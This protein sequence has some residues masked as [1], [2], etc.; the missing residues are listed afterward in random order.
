MNLRGKRQQN[1]YA[2]SD[3]AERLYPLR[4]ES[5]P[6]PEPTA[7]PPG[8]QRV[9]VLAARV[10]LGQQL[11]NLLDS[12]EAR[13]GVLGNGGVGD[14]AR[15]CSRVPL[16]MIAE[17]GGEDVLATIREQEA[18]ARRVVERAEFQDAVFRLNRLL[19]KFFRQAAGVGMR[20]DRVRGR[21][22]KWLNSEA[23]RLLAGE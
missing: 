20:T 1:G 10:L 19:D 5:L 13:V 3:R 18:S 12:R 6:L 21:L 23:A 4:Q 15:S 8:P 14:I 16:Q 2:P 11:F 17:H 9:V 7:I 22:T